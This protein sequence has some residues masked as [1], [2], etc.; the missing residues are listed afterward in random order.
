MSK[1]GT[2]ADLTLSDPDI[3]IPIG[4]PNP[5]ARSVQTPIILTVDIVSCHIPK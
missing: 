4:I 5:I 2:T 1:I 3:S